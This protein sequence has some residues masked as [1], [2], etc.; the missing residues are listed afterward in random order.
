MNSKI[1][2]LAALAVMLMLV[3][4]PA[5]AAAPTSVTLQMIGGVVSPGVQAYSQQGG[6]LAFG[7]LL[8]VPMDPKNTV[9]H[10]SLTAL[11][12]GLSAHGFASFDISGVSSHQ[13]HVDVR[14]SIVIASMTPAV[15]FPLGCSPGVDCTAAIPAFFNGLATVQV[16]TSAGT[17]TMSLPMSFES[18]YLNPFGAPILFSSAG[19]ELVVASTYTQARIRWTGVVMGGSVAG[20][21]GTNPV[22]GSFAMIVNSSEDLKAGVEMDV[23]MISFFGM[24][25]PSMNAAGYFVGHSMIPTSPSVPCDGFPPGTCSLTG[26]K[27]AGVFF[28]KTAGGGSL[29]GKYATEWTVPAVGFGSLVTGSF[30]T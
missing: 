14:G 10:F 8:G 11:V 17:T 19:S 18:A 28:Q 22:S 13:E 6:Q 24:S 16:H 20:M 7:Y 21:A 5:R 26:L 3:A 27:S 2:V 1:L 23:G 29:I 30:R 12:S 9:V 25:D 15:L 4:S